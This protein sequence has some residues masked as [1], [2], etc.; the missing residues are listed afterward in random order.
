MNE[1]MKETDYYKILGL[2]R[3]E[4]LS[5]SSSSSSSSSNS[6]VETIIQKAYR[7]RAVQTHPDKTNGDRRAFDK[8]AE[9]YD[10][11]SD[12]NKRTINNKYGKQGLDSTINMSGGTGASGF[13]STT[14][15]MASEDIFRLFFR[16]SCCI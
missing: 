11:L 5:S 7:K 8:V 3:N 16:S 12:R 15:G 10:V 4:I 9:A 1:I 2:D 6:N 14:T 13:S